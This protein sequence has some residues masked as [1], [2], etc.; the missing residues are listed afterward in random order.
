[1][2]CHNFFEQFENKDRIENLSV[3][4]YQVKDSLSK[5]KQYCDLDMMTRIEE[6]ASSDVR[7]TISK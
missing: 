3:N 5:L 2:K 4:N 1:M 6:E 7:S